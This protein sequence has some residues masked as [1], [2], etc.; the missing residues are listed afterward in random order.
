MIRK[1][2]ISTPIT[3]LLAKEFKKRM[4]LAPPPVP[5][6]RPDGLNPFMPAFTTRTDYQTDTKTD[7]GGDDID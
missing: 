4:E 5:L 7:S 3:F 1:L 6:T 2:H